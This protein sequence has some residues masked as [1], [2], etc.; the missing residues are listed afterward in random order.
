MPTTP[1]PTPTPSPT[2][3]TN[4]TISGQIS[5]ATLIQHERCTKSGDGYQIAL[6]GRLSGIGIGIVIGTDATG[7]I[8]FGQPNPG[9]SVAVQYGGPG[10]SA[11]DYWFATAGDPG[12]AGTMT[13]EDNGSG[14]FEGVA[15]PP[16]VVAPAGTTAPVTLAGPWI[17]T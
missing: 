11:D 1:G 6:R 10:A 2:P 13:L 3:F 14:S 9:V 12:T 7:T 4:W 15:V 17:Y 5:G 16:S 8:D